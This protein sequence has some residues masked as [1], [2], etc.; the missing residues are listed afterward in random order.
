MK[1]REF[2]VVAIVAKTRGGNE[3]LDIKSDDDDELW[4]SLMMVQEFVF[5]EESIEG[6]IGIYRVYLTASD[7]KQDDAACNE[8]AG[9]MRPEICNDCDEEEPEKKK[10]VRSYEVRATVLLVAFVGLY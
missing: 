1:E 8:C 10:M 3:V 9:N 2:E 7:K 5:P 4:D 6:P